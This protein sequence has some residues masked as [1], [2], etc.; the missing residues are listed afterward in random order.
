MG[1]APNKIAFEYRKNLVFT[2]SKIAPNELDAP[3]RR[4]AGDYTL[5]RC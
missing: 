5:P 2:D 3:H 1:K 4:A